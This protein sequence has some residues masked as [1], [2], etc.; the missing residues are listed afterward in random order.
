[1][2]TTIKRDRQCNVLTDLVSW[3]HN[4]HL[5][6]AWYMVRENEAFLFLLG[7]VEKNLLTLYFLVAG[8]TVW[9]SI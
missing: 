1:M 7:I 8:S 5:S 4:K 6:M 9:I 2:Y 3:L